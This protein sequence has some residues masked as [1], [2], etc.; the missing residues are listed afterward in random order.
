MRV[1]VA[2]RLGHRTSR[3]CRAAVGAE[4][5]VIHRIEHPA[6]HGLETVAHLRERAAH[7]HAHRVVDVAALHLLLDVDQFYS[8]G[9]WSVG[10]QRGVSHR[11][12]LV[13]FGFGR[14]LNVKEAHVSCVPGDEAATGFDVLAHQN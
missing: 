7:D 12:L 1:I 14:R 2:H 4:T 5:R 6:V 8:V 3:F 13:A 10:R 11:I 9:R